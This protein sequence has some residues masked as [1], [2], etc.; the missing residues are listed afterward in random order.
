MGLTDLDKNPFR[1]GQAAGPGQVV[2]H[3]DRPMDEPLKTLPGG[4]WL[5]IG[6]IRDNTTGRIFDL[7]HVI[8]AGGTQIVPVYTANERAYFTMI[9]IA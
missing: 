6:S 9:R 4:T 1:L 8:V 7:T 5:C 2:Q 3:M